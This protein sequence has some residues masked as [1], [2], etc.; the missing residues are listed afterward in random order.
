RVYPAGRVHYVGRL[1]LAFGTSGSQ[2]A[3]IDRRGALREALH[4]LI[5]LEQTE[6]AVG[7]ESRRTEGHLPLDPAPLAPARR[8]VRAPP[9]LAAV[10]RPGELKAVH[11]VPSGPAQLE[12][13]SLTRGYVHPVRRKEEKRSGLALVGRE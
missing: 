11:E 9:D 2:F 7:Q 5:H 12:D 3:G 13:F 8:S 10:A 1:N 4:H 6:D